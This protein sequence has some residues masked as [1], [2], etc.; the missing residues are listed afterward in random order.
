MD[1]DEYEKERERV[2]AELKGEQQEEML[3]NMAVKPEGLPS[4]YTPKQF[5]K[6]EMQSKQSSMMYTHSLKQT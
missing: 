3:E 4:L 1:A 5:N 2:I 6:K